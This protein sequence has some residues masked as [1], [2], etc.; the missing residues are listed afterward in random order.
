MSGYPN[1]Q[2]FA[3][4]DPGRTSFCR[5]TF[6]A[7]ALPCDPTLRSANVSQGAGGSEVGLWEAATEAAA[8]ALYVCCRL[9]TVAHFPARKAQHPH[10]TR[11]DIRATALSG[12]AAYKLCNR[13]L[14]DGFIAAGLQAETLP[15]QWGQ[16][17]LLPYCLFG[18][19]PKRVHSSNMQCQWRRLHA[20]Y[21]QQL[22][23]ATAGPGKLI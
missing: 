15:V 14:A 4:T 22:S 13:P 18:A 11:I 21:S 6:S 9:I 5:A 8:V 3:L 17:R 10:A 23:C 12:N 20:S 2:L 7:F 19:P 16:S 1:N